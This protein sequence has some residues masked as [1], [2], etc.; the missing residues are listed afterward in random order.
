MIAY[1]NTPGTA[2]SRN[3]SVLEGRGES[4]EHHHDNPHHFA[5]PVYHHFAED[6]FHVATGNLQ[7]FLFICH[8]VPYATEG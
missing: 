3:L 6:V 7:G 1:E 4:P 8:A 2:L 5:E